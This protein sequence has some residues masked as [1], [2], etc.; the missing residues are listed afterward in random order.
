M[1][2]PQILQMPCCFGAVAVSG[3]RTYAS[4]RVRGGGPFAESH[5]NVL[6]RGPIDGCRTRFEQ[7]DG[8]HGSSVGAR[9]A[10][11]GNAVRGFGIAQSVAR[12]LLLT[13]QVMVD[14]PPGDLE[15]GAR[16]IG[17]DLGASQL[18][19]G[20]TYRAGCR[21]HGTVAF[22]HH[23]S[24]ILIGK[25]GQGFQG[26]HT[27]VANQDQPLKPLDHAGE[28]PHAAFVTNAVFQDQMP[29]IQ[30]D[31]DV[32]AKQGYNAMFWKAPLSGGLEPLL[33]SL[34]IGRQCRL[35]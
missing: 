11:S 35:L 8:I 30:V 10:Q 3:F 4:G 24:R 18:G 29:A 26:H 5:L 22:Q 28:A 1:D 9:G 34:E 16:F 25:P 7:A 2:I 23:E 19:I 33:E 27:V 15:G 20:R 6:P 17:A 13:D 31:F 14:Q 12:D 32:V 21:E